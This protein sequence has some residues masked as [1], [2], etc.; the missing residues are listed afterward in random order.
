[1]KWPDKAKGRASDA[2]RPLI[3]HKRVVPGGWCVWGSETRGLALAKRCSP[4]EVRFPIRRQSLSGQLPRTVSHRPWGAP[5]SG[6][7]T[8]AKGFR[9]QQRAR[10]RGTC[11][12]R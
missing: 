3:G 7:Q 2:R 8:F 9:L 10:G 12:K 11:G 6:G 1:M 4:S 5:P